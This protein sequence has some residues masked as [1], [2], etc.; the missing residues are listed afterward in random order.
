MTAQIIDEVLA[1]APMTIFVIVLIAVY[2]AK[3]NE[4]VPVARPGKTYACARCGRRGNH[5]H[6][7]PVAHEGAVVWYCAHCSAYRAR[8][9]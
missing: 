8:S 6:R 5:E 1:W 3:R 4:R 7:V 9:S 2:L